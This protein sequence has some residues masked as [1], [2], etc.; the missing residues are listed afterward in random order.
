MGKLLAKSDLESF[1]KLSGRG[2]ICGT[3]AVI[4]FEE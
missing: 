4:F 3:I 2:I 1:T